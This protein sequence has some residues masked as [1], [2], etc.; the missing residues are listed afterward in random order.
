MSNFL[1]E[2]SYL[3]GSITFIIGLKRLSGPD[4]ARN[5]NLMA[6]AGMGIAILAKKKAKPL[7]ISHGYWVLWVLAP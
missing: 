3:I 2:L 5:G 7:A 4:T 1:L 6:A